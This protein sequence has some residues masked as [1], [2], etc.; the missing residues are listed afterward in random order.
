[1][2]TPGRKTLSVLCPVYN[3]E[4]V[5]LD[6]HAELVRVVNDLYGRFDTEIIYVVDRGTDRTLELLSGVAAGDARVGAL[7][8]VRPS[9]VAARRHRSRA[10]RRRGHAR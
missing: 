4:E 9:D 2:I 3:E 8:A 6:F 7:H 1:M 10:R 5:I